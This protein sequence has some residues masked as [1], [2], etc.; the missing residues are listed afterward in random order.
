VLRQHLNAA[1]EGQGSVVLVGGAAGTG[2][3]TLA[4]AITAEAARQGALVLVGR[5]YD[6]METPPYGPWLELFGRYRSPESGPCLPP[7]FAQRGGVGAVA[8]QAALFQEVGD[9]LVALT[10][11]CPVVLL[12]DDLHWSDPVSLE[13]LRF[14]AHSVAT[15]PLLILLTYR[16]DELTRRH[17]LSL[18][19]PLLEREARAARLT[20][21]P[22]P[23]D[24]VR[25]LVA[26]RYAPS[27]TDGE[28]LVAY[29]IARAEGNAFFMTQVLTA[30][31]EEGVLHQ[32][33]GRWVVG[34]VASAHVPVALRQVIDGRVA[35]LDEDAQEALAVAAV[36]GQ[37]APFDVWA[38]V[39]GMDEDALGAVV[40]QATVARLMEETPDGVG[41]RFVHAL[42]REAIYEGIL[43]S[44]R[45]RLHRS[46]GET[47]AALP[48]P[49]ADAV[50]YHFRA[51]GDARTASWLVKAG[52][53]AREARAV[54][55]A[56]E[57]MEE[58]I[59]LLEGREHAALV[60]NLALQIGYMLRRT[61]LPRA[62][63]YSEEAIHRAEEAD[64]PAMAGIARCQLGYALF[65]ARQFVRALAAL[66][67]GVA[68]L[69]ML[70]PDAWERTAAP[71]G[72]VT[73]ISLADARAL[74]AWILTFVG[75]HDEALGLLGLT[76]DTADAALDALGYYGRLAVY[77]V[78][79][80]RGRPD[81]ARRAHERA[82]QD[83][84]AGEDSRVLAATLTGFFQRTVLC[85]HADDRAAIGEAVA[86]AERAWTRAQTMQLVVPFPLRVL[87][88]S[89]D[90]IGGAW[91]A[92]QTA[93]PIAQRHSGLRQNSDVTL[94]AMA[95]SQG[96]PDDAWREV[97]QGLPDG[98][99]TDPGTQSLLASL[100]FL[101]IGGWLM[102]D[103]G[104]LDGARRW[105]EAHDR[106]LA[107][108]GAVQGQSEGRALWAQLHRQAGDLR[109]AHVHAERAL[110]HAAAPHQ[111]L[112][113][114]AA[115]RLLGEIDTETGRFD[116]AAHHLAA[117]LALADACAAPFERALTLLAIAVLHAARGTIEEARG[118]LD[119]ARTS[120][121]CLGA[122]P[123]LARADALTARLAAAAQRPPIYPAGLSAREVEVLR[124]LAVGK[125]N[126]EIA[127]ALFL[128]SNTVRVHVRNI[129]T[130]T[131]TENRTAAAAF[132]RAHDLA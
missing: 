2:K 51:I 131:G 45:R 132:A 116:D 21:R 29:L 41:A 38:T 52:E 127:D 42:I 39:A 78:A 43:P 97:R 86:A 19:L 59:G 125:T 50:A 93:L 103:A 22:L 88:Y 27:E 70:S 10:A 80:D 119:E 104:D 73:I 123:A 111:P 65:I 118:P 35:R 58:A 7:A 37:E 108:S 54:V 24:A 62:I 25:E 4:E 130:K 14:V 61:D 90:F 77:Q 63:R 105:A 23:H 89:L 74:L 31:E 122:R 82:R 124:L 13:L 30:L 81:L 91:D 48:N 66:R 60:G 20:L 9:F 117:S 56:V 36:I 71:N 94:A 109:A 26:A 76:L 57:R 87:R 1:R 83:L 75:A 67:A 113:L 120:F 47:L 84:Q 34:D 6:L 114:L 46:V 8:S 15:L 17:P 16:D 112:A 12:L 107:W 53:R 101:Q 55:T 64:D 49:D 72:G 102:L 79:N 106:W 129:M 33:E 5:C 11:A 69:E 3:T 68:A 98:S 92:V 44:R 85:Y 28:T 110:A 100:A 40:E 121:A 115:H 96:K 99:A 18:L 126:R 95:R 128:S 32:V